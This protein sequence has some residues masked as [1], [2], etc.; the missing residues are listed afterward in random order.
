M[1]FLL[2]NPMCHSNRYINGIS[3]ISQSDSFKPKADDINEIN[4]WGLGGNAHAQQ[5]L[6]SY[7]VNPLLTEP[8]RYV[9]VYSSNFYSISLVFNCLFGFFSVRLLKHEIQNINIQ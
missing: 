4:T 2:M 5:A 9:L 6:T 7:N 8:T 3:R 1:C